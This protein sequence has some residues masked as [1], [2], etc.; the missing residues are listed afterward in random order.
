[1]VLRLIK[2]QVGRSCPQEVPGRGTAGMM[3]GGLVITSLAG[4]LRRAGLCLVLA[5]ILLTASP[6]SA[7]VGAEVRAL[8]GGR[9]R[10]VWVRDLDKGTDLFA[11]SDKFRLMC[12]DSDDG[13]GERELVPGPG[14][15]HRPTITPDGAH[16]IYT[17]YLT[18]MMYVVNWDGSGRRELGP[19][20]AIAAWTDPQTGVE[21]IYAQTGK[22]TGTESRY[23]PVR[24]FRLDDPRA[25]ETVWDRTPVNPEGFG[26]ASDGKR[27]VSLF[28]WPHVGVATF[29]NE[30]F[31]ELGQGCC[32]SLAPGAAEYAFN[33]LGDHRNLVM[34]ALATGA[35]WKVTLSIAPGVDGF[36]IYHPKWTNRV[37]YL[38]MCGPFKG[39]VGSTADIY[40]GRF[41]GNLKAVEAWVRVTSDDKGDF[42]PDAWIAPAAPQTVKFTLS[43]N[44]VNVPSAE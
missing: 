31:V 25:S 15:F 9:T 34:Y 32:A 12:L 24:R 42:Y 33:L 27:V 11:T 30:S 37:R 3:R 20:T 5:A 2:G 40:L 23:N 16:V 43:G 28:P 19:G 6:V 17:N 8:T 21:W 7:G 1:M 22:F 36:E 44:M 35:K 41:D 38:V 29:P 13:A 4:I 14:S 26:V 10:V 39:D 18:Q